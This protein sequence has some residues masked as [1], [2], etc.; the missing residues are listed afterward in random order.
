MI[1]RDNWKTS[2]KATRVNTDLERERE[3]SN[4]QGQPVDRLK[5]HKSIYWV[6]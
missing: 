4:T 5:R 3:P 1:L 2:L 6:R